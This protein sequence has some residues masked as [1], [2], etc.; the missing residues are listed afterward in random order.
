VADSQTIL[1]PLYWADYVHRD[2]RFTVVA[3][4]RGL[5]F[6][7]LP[8]GRNRALTDYFGRHPQ[9]R[10]VHEPEFLR[11]YL[12][13]LEQYFTHQRHG[14]SVTLD[15]LSGTAFQRKVWQVLGS[16]PYG[17]TWSY[18]DLAAAAGCPTAIRAV[19]SAVAKNPIAL[20]IPCHR[21]IGSDGTLTGFGGGLQLKQELLELEGVSEFKAKGHAKYAF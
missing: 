2:Q 10:A 13:Q 1:R 6:L 3:S 15:I 4:D 17:Q 21:V 9:F 19:A 14:F 11:A 16:I 7:A 8:Y 20:V 12:D 18:A 5:S